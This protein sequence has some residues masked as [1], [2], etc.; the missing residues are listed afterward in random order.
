[1]GDGN[2]FPLADYIPFE[3]L[4]AF[5]GEST[6]GDWTL[7]IEDTFAGL[8]SG[9]LNSWGFTYDYEV[10]PTPLDV[11]LDASGMA[12][13][14][15]ADLLLN[16]DE[17]C[18]WTATA[19]SM[20][21]NSLTTTFAGGN[22][23]SGNMFDIMAVNDL[24]VQ[25]FD[26][27]MDAGTTDDVEIYFK[28]GTWV[29]FD[30]D[31]GAWTLVE[32]VTDVTSEGDN[33]PTPLNT[34][35][36]I[37][38]AAGETVA[39]YVTLVNTTNI[40]YTDGT[41][42]GDLFASDA[43]LEF[44]EGAG[45]AYPFDLTFDPRVFNGNI[46]Y[47]VD[48][49][50]TTMDFTCADLG[51]NQIDVTVTD[52]SG[53]TAMCTATVNILDETAPVITCGPP[54]N[55]SDSA[56]D[57]PAL[58]IVDNTTVSTTLSVTDDVTITDLNVDLD[59]AH[60]WTGDLE[61]TLESPA[62]T[63]ALIFSGAADGCSGDNI[64]DL[65]DDESANALACAAGSSDAFPLDDYMPSNP[66]SVFD[67]ESTLG[68]WTL[69]IEDTAGGDS[70]VLN[71][72][73]LNYSYP[74]PNP[75]SVIELDEN[76][77]AV[78]DPF[79]LISSVDEACGID[80]A[81]VDITE[82]FCSDIGTTLEITVFVS[83]ASGNIA[84]CVA[85]VD[86]VD[87]MAP[88]L[89]C[90]AD[91]TVDPGAGN[92]NYEVPDYFADGDATATDNCTDPVTILT[93]DPAPGTLLPDGVYTVTLTAEDEYG[94]VATCT[95]ELTVES[96]FGVEDVLAK[97]VSIYPNPARNVINITNGSAIGLDNATIY[98][99]NGRLVQTIDLTNMT[100]EKSVDVSQLASGVYMVNIQGEGGNTIKRLIKE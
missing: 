79:D 94:N 47:D 2:A 8:D 97:E 90:P 18:G 57:S 65:L 50:S 64:M 30:Q 22:G 40:A 28:T 5:D 91:Q 29:G 59:I 20:S 36:D 3:A 31:P 25:S 89:T 17:A 33:V 19:G 58:A 73:A 44:Y 26:V 34:N 68:D 71:T 82:V 27:S 53:N 38:V 52:D 24:T 83:D 100:T 41:T 76:G 87:A 74:N 9:I 86:V 46:V 84:S 43:N 37:D 32:T 39:F 60:T 81:A 77:M 98:D 45:K 80:T 12:T 88:E 95:F 93:Q 96:T 10:V 49:V 14:N 35:L 99:V 42:T 15:I 6:L 11:V 78:V 16:V 21:T 1:N 55:V 13:V 4:S 70:G 67:G 61:I 66:L 69:S 62:G 48:G 23:Q 75:N 56:S 54:A 51:E 72:W 85:M 63:Q 7:T 92:L